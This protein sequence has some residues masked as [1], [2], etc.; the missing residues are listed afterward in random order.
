M[1]IVRNQHSPKE[2]PQENNAG[3]IYDPQEAVN[4]MNEIR[5][6]DDLEEPNPEGDYE[7]THPND[8][9]ITKKETNQIQL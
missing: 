6:D 8:P 5:V 2:A 9:Q 4:D 1:V 7:P 3:R